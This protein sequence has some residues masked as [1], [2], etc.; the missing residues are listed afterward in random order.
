[1][2]AVERALDG[3]MDSV[4][5]PSYIGYACKLL[6]LNRSFVYLLANTAHST[7]Y[8]HTHTPTHNFT[9]FTL[10]WPKSN[11]LFSILYRRAADWMWSNRFAFFAYPIFLWPRSLRVHAL[12]S[13]RVS[14]HLHSPYGLNG[15]ERAIVK[16]EQNKMRRKKKERKTKNEKPNK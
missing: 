10:A 15:T 8:T 12:S 5:G 1:M 16:M 14:F 3:R 6:Y 2:V 11:A 13:C 7:Q 9:L 4:I